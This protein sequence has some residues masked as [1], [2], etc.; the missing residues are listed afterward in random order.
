[1]STWAV[2]QKPFFFLIDFEMQKPVLCPL[3]DAIIDTAEKEPIELG[4]LVGKARA[5][6]LENLNMAGA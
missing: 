3:E 4:D 5:D 2:A 6:Q 1:M